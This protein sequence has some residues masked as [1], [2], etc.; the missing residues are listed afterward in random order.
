MPIYM[1]PY[2]DPLD[3]T[4]KHHW[5]TPHAPDCR[6]P[7]LQVSIT[8]DGLGT[9][10]FHIDL[11]VRNSDAT[12]STGNF[13]VLYGAYRTA[14]FASPPKVDKFIFN[15]ILNVAAPP[16][17]AG[18]FNSVTI[19]GR[20]SLGDAPWVPPTGTVL[21]TPAPPDETTQPY[22]F[23]IVATVAPGATFLPTDSTVD[24]QVA[25]WVGP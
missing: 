23:V 22:V 14:P 18:P 19:T 20:V 9:K 2:N 21:W 6:N 5:D 15:S 8:T 12:A 24:A 3:A 4:G 7:S 25:V 11:S 1:G 16:I 17:L 13:V 10:T